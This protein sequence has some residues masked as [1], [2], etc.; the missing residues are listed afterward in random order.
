MILVGSIR[1]K[2]ELSIKENGGLSKAI[3]MLTKIKNVNP[4]I[5]WA[6]IIQMGGALAVELAG[7]P[8]IDMLYGREDCL[9]ENY[10][11]RS[12]PWLPCPCPPYSDGSH[13]PDIHLRTIFYRMG[14]TNRE[15]VSL[16]GA[17]TLGRIF[18]ERTGILEH[19]DGNQFGEQRHCSGEQ[20]STKYTRLT[21]VAKSTGES[22]I[23]MPGG[24]S[25]TKNWLTFDNSYYNPAPRHIS[26]SICVHSTTADQANVSSVQCYELE[27][28]VLLPNYQA[29]F[30]SPEFIQYSDVYAKD[31]QKWFDD[32][33]QAHKKMSELGVRWRIRQGRNGVGVREG[34][35]IEGKLE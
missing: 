8:H 6:D 16:C 25:W 21:A 7:G 30:L 18:R 14:F 9:R 13:S 28:L 33:R 1:F 12:T 3:I 22:G 17:H 27:D 4:E 26:K 15:M 23:G 20:G 19:F 34:I 24:I 5:S 10:E 32:Y 2:E 29:L 35:S 31:Q 11:M